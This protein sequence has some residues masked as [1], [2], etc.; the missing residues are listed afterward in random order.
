MP[1]RWLWL[2][3]A[4]VLLEPVA[5]L[6]Q[7]T[8][9]DDP[10]FDPNPPLGL[11]PTSEDAL[12]DP[13]MARSWAT[14]PPRYFIATTADIGF[15]YARPRVSLGYGRPFTAWVGIDANPLVTNTGLGAYAGLRF[16]LPFADLRIGPRYFSSFSHTVLGI[17]SHY[18]RLALETAAGEKAKILT[19]EAELDIN[20]PLGPGS[21]LARGSVSYVT[22]VD[23]NHAAFE[24]TLRLIVTPPLVW[25]VRTGYAWNFGAYRQH[26]IG[27]VADLLDVP[28]R[29]D[30]ITFRL[31]PIMRFVLSRRVELRGSFVITVISRDRI[32]LVGGDFTELGVRYRWASE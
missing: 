9:P 23:K 18:D 13:R 16:A 6:A 14:L 32:G 31:G 24:E 26:S 12:M 19:Y 29:E 20:I 22:G 17:E 7:S 1:A 28:R 8:P 21:L 27:L 3:S 25:R 4:A 10:S 5:A 2:L 15:V 11:L 30:S